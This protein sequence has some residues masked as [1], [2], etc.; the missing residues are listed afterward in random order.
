M[1]RSLVA[2]YTP[3]DGLY[4]QCHPAPH[5]ADQLHNSQEQFQLASTAPIGPHLGPCGTGTT[6]SLEM[7]GAFVTFHDEDWR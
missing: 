3:T 7:T 4:K 1:R 6:A 5:E 2:H